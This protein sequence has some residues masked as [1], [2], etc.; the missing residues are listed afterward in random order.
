MDESKN[1]D[2]VPVKESVHYQ[3]LCFQ[4]VDVKLSARIVRR[5]DIAQRSSSQTD[6]MVRTT[7]LK[8]QRWPF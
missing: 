1:D 3:C 4:Q 2:A 6:I 5:D 8:Q 7:H